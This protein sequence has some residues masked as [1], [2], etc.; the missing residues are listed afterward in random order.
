MQFHLLWLW[1]TTCHI[2]W[3]APVQNDVTVSGKSFLG[4][5]YKCGS[6]LS[7]AT[8]LEGEILVLAFQNLWNGRI[9]NSDW[10]LWTGA[11]KHL[12]IY[13][14]KC[15][16]MCKYVKWPNNVYPNTLIF[17]IATQNLIPFF[18]QNL[19][20]LQSWHEAWLLVHPAYT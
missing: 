8:L 12:N 1:K 10:A 20:L 4:I 5:C 11:N 3:G 2:N 15:I 18:H 6:C 16:K 14:F 7:S 9:F 17:Y 19:I 13:I